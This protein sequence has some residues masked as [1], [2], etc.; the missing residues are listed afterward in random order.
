MKLSQDVMIYLMSYVKYIYL[1]HR[2]G[3]I[4]LSSVLLELIPES[5][6]FNTISFYDH[7]SE[8][9]Y[10]AMDQSTNQGWFKVCA[11][12]MRNVVTK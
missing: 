1:Y 12:A 4:W 8:F 10:V 7:Q 5:V 11:Q 3:D 6:Y 2:I 9:H